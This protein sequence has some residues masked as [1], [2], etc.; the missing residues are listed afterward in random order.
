MQMIIG[1]KYKW[2]CGHEILTYLGHNWSGNGYWHQFA[3]IEKPEE[4]W[5][6]VLDR[7]LR[8][9]DE[10]DPEPDPAII[11]EGQSLVHA[12]AEWANDMP[13]PRR[14]MVALRERKEP[15]DVQATRISAAEA[16]RQRRAERNRK[17]QESSNVS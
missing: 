7:D 9:L 4:I 5:C 14:H 2:K 12:V 17:W 3:L 6:E 10:V 15:V 13:S 11:T 1:N 8:L 16:K